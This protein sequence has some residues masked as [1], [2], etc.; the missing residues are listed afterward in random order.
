MLRALAHDPHALD[1][2]EKLVDDLSKTPEGRE[3]LPVGLD[4]ILTPIRAVR[5]ASE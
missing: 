3:L 5:G 4:E 1:Q 2:V